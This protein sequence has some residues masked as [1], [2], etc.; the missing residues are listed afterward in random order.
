MMDT[1]AVV[2][3]VRTLREG[4][5]SVRAA[6]PWLDMAVHSEETA[7]FPHCPEFKTDSARASD[8]KPLSLRELEDLKQDNVRLLRLRPERFPLSSL[9]GT[10]D[11]M[12][13]TGVPLV[14][15]HTD[16]DFDAIRSLAKKRPMLSII[17]ESG[18]KKL[19]YHIEEIKRTLAACP[20][21]Y[22]CSFNFCNWRGHEELVELGLGH[23]LLFGSHSP[24]YGA[25]AAMG[26]IIMGDFGW[27]RK[28]D[29]AGNN[30]RRLLGMTAATPP[31]VRF[32]PPPPFIVDA[33][34]HNVSPGADGVKG[35]PMPTPDFSFTPADWLRE[36]SRFAI[37]KMLLTP[38]ETLFDAKL[39]CLDYTES[40]R[41][42]APERFYFFEIFH[43]NAGVEHL[44]R[45]RKSLSHP[46]CVGVKIHPVNAKIPGDDDSYAP[47]YKLASETHK[48]IMTHSWEI[49]NYNPA[50]RNGH[51]DRFRRYLEEFRTTPFILGHAGGRPSAFEATVS[52]L[53]DFPNVYVDLAG[54]YLHSGMI[55]AFAKAVGHERMLFA[56]DVDWF[57]P[58]CMTALVLG[59]GL[60]D[61]ALCDVLRLNAL[62]VYGRVSLFSRR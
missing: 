58:A 2:S 50:Q 7:A 54:D 15:F 33:H 18:P 34:A 49:S 4:Y 14:V 56:T 16:M 32:S 43:P 55:D 17:I 40:L 23:K 42:L 8:A 1:D 62:N 52:V 48:P 39:T 19:I 28:C 53:K 51:P 9:P 38:G 20:N 60:S 59:S 6:L 41:R 12:E 46:S 13:K 27:E 47:I 11:A 61:E 22:L 25:D 31:E 37:D 35:Y 36:I 29:I 24:L 21:V 57:D 45:I 44:E 5:R 30:L 26:P 10:L 3:H